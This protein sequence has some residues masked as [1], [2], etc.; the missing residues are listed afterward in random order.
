MLRWMETCD[1]SLPL[2][3]SIL[4]S[5]VLPLCAVVK[6]RCQIIA[7]SQREA[8]SCHYILAQNFV[9]VA[10]LLAS[11]KRQHPV[12]KGYIQNSPFIITHTL[13]RSGQPG[14]T[15]AVEQAVYR[16]SA[17]DQRAMDR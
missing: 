6:E 4:D 16:M 1:A 2:F 12:R 17:I 8:L 10:P 7:V 13:S 11:S 5:G 15:T 3:V 9:C 14:A